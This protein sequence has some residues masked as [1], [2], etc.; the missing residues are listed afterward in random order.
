MNKNEIWAKIKDRKFDIP[1]KEAVFSVIEE[2][3]HRIEFAKDH[4]GLRDFF[5]IAEQGTE[6]FFT[7]NMF[8]AINVNVDKNNSLEE[9]FEEFIKSYYENSDLMVAKLKSFFAKTNRTMFVGIGFVESTNPNLRKTKVPFFNPEGKVEDVSLYE[10]IMSI[11]I[12]EGKAESELDAAKKMRLFP[13]W[14]DKFAKMPEDL[15][16]VT[17][18]E[19]NAEFEKEKKLELEKVTNE[20]NLLLDKENHTEEDKEKFKELSIIYKNLKGN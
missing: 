9:N 15:D 8:L 11:A 4:I 7:S 17:I 18:S 20:I 16:F 13:D 12:K 14:Y 19:E 2:N 6:D 3:L 1:Y 5:F 10:L